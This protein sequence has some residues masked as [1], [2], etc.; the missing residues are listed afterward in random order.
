MQK[1][2]SEE[3][4][5]RFLN[6][7]ES[8]GHLIVKSESLLPLNDPT[9]LFTGS[10]MQPMLPYLLGKKHPGGVKISDIQK[11]FRADEIDEVGDN[12]HTTSFEMAGNWSFGDYFK[13]EQI[14]WIFEFLTDEKKG[15]GLDPRRLYVTAFIGDKKNGL[16]KDI[17]AGEEWRKVFESINME[18]KE[19]EMGSAY[20]ASEK[21][22]D[23]G[24]IFYYDA[25][26]NWWSRAGV[27]DNMP[28]GEPGGP[29]SEM[30]Y[31]YGEFVKHDE[32]FGKECHPAC[33]CGRFVEIGNNVFMTYKKIGE[34][35][36]EELPNKNIDHGSGF[37][38]WVAAANNQ[39][40]FFKTDI[41]EDT[42]KIL[43]DSSGKSYD[44]LQYQK[45]F[46]II[47]DHI[48]SSVLILSDGLAPSNKQ[49]GYILRRLIRRAVLNMEKIGFD[50]NDTEKLILAVSEKY[51]DVYKDIKT[52]SD[53][54]K[55][56][57]LN[58]ISGFKK[59]LQK[60]MKEF[61]KMID[62][63]NNIN[64]IRKVDFGEID[65]SE[66]A[67]NEINTDDAFKLVSTYGFPKELILEEAEKKNIFLDYQKLEKKLKEHSEQS[68]IASAVKFK[69]GLGGDS[70]KIVA[71]HTAT[72]LLL[73]ALRKFV[74]DGVHQKGSNI[75]EERTR[76][77]F[78]CGQK[79]EREILDKIEEYIN[80]AI[81]RGGEVLTEEMD[82][83]DAKESEV[84]GSFWEKY[85][86]IVKVW[87]IKNGDDIFSRELCSGPHVKN[88]SEISEFGKFKIVKEESSSSGVRRIKA[89]FEQ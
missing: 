44:N 70:K 66:D 41:F 67:Q 55:E 72:H 47:V 88:I 53:F 69:S 2:T 82:K 77:D 32:K 30:F 75:T 74:G 46:R 15:L 31:D 43:E 87:T 56:E 78:S 28:V 29:D 11:C 13:K 62:S 23:G 83:N 58:E 5:K 25:K 65:N 8:K 33:D 16:K 64:N 45:K 6:F 68:S 52:K 51:G 80:N 7:M 71:F 19:V 49:A 35:N 60:G 79:V 9:T 22:M 40:D 12:R 73:G 27:P 48:K 76:F 17:E 39:N 63:E 86:D 1:I 59:T 36:F 34:N 57:L 14:N 84:E 54:I 20:D 21:G 50:F 4:R 37:E 26:E 81:S 3:I 85:P 24:R 61:E 38:R 89:I 42:I 18:A 10:G